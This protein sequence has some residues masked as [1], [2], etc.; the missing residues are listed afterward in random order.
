VDDGTL[1]RGH[2]KEVLEAHATSGE[3][4]AAIIAARGLRQISDA[5]A[6]ADAVAAALAAN[7]TAVADY[8]AGKEQ[9]MKFLV[10]QVMKAT[11]GQADA[12]AVQAAVRERLDAG[13]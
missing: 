9:A 12:T 7:P 2:G 6:I 5:T 8:R 13:S 1:S 4:A 11:R 10:G 3:T